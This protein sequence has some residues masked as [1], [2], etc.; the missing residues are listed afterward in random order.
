MINDLQDLLIEIK[1]FENFF[2]FTILSNKDL[3]NQIELKIKE[4]KIILL[5]E[6]NSILND[7]IEDNLQNGV[8]VYDRH[9]KI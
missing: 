3:D 7:T 1:E 2:Y 5:E 9:S 4:I 6:I 8:A